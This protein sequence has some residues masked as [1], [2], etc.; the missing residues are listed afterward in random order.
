[1][2]GGVSSTAFVIVLSVIVVVLLSLSIIMVMQREG[3]YNNQHHRAKVQQNTLPEVSVALSET[4]GAEPHKPMVV[5]LH[6]VVAS[7]PPSTLQ[8]TVAAIA[9]N[10]PYYTD[11]NL[12][13]MFVHETPSLAGRYLRQTVQGVMH[14]VPMRVMPVAFYKQVKE[15]EDAKDARVTSWTPG[16]LLDGVG[17][18]VI[19]S[20]PGLYV[21]YVSSDIGQNGLLRFRRRRGARHERMLSGETVTLVFNTL[22]NNAS[23]GFMI[24]HVPTSYVLYF[25]GPLDYRTRV[26][27]KM[28][29]VR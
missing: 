16:V 13:D 10:N 19:P 27:Y 29:D 6:E 20:T 2:N 8:K 4:T 25:D 14:V 7:E 3:M 26:Y 15:L 18:F 24:Q 28:R 23:R 9:H 21:E 11:M 5:N 12:Q 22:E 17:V 1:M